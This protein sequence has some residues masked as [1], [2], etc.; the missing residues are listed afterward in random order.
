MRATPL[1][2]AVLMAH[3]GWPA[4]YP[5]NSLAGVR[6]ALDAGAAMVEVDVQLTADGVPVVLHD[7]TLARTA[8][9]GDSIFDLP[10]SAA[11]GIDVGEPGRLGAAAEA[12][13]LPTLDDV[14]ALVAAYSGATLFIEAK[15]ESIQR[16]GRAA[17]ATALLERIGDASDHVVVA[18]DAVFLERIRAQRALRIGWILAA[19]DDAHEH[20]AR[21]LAPDFLFCAA[22]AVADTGEA[23]W[24]GAG[25]WV[26]YDVAERA[27]AQELLARGAA[28]VETDDIGG[29]LGAVGSDPG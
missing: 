21:R 26:V 24:R 16:F 9:R 20:Q 23:L 18:V 14:L 12:T 4:R 29:W 19:L 17:L 13:P 27:R 1:S 28:I 8:E 2:P 7:A 6:A 3:R 5:E 25:T 22:A 10:V 11:P 15:S